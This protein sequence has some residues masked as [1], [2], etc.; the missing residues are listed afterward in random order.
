MPTAHTDTPLPWT[1]SERAK[2]MFQNI[3]FGRQA[4]SFSQHHILTP[5]PPWGSWTIA[6]KATIAPQLTA[7]LLKPPG[8]IDAADP[9]LPA[10]FVG[11]LQNTCSKPIWL[12]RPLTRVKSIPSASHSPL[13]L[14]TR[15]DTLNAPHAHGRVVPVTTQTRMR[16][17]CD[18]ERACHQQQHLA[19][20]SV[21]MFAA[22]L[23]LLVLPPPPPSSFQA[24]P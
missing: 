8:G 16:G 3:S 7:T 24:P 21:T 12:I 15:R 2:A 1:D 14:R 9:S 13:R 4:V 19:F 18:T 23:G 11:T 20:C 6:R 10:A 22:S 17:M 5:S